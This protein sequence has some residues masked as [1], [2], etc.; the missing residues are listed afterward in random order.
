MLARGQPG[1]PRVRTHGH[2]GRG[3]VPR[4]RVRAVPDA[5]RRLRARSAG[6]DLGGRARAG[7]R[8]GAGG[9]VVVAVGPR[10]RR[11]RRGGD[12]GRMRL[13][14]RGQLRHGRDEHRRV[15]RSR[16]SSRTDRGAR[17]RGLPDPAPG[18]R[19]AH[20]GR[21]RWLDRA[22]RRGR[23]AGRGS[24]QRG[25]RAGARVLRPRRRRPDGHRRR[26]RARPHPRRFA[27]PGSRSARRCRGPPRARAGGRH[28]GRASCAS[29]TPRWNARCGS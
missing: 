11:A 28:R 24:A 26:S 21:G 14:R 1:V 8:R 5:A 27:L 10:G 20:G 19:R 29:S 16:S 9:G 7:D 3:G 2:D 13:R 22:A 25:S 6:D 15:P 23:R 17:R 4:A 12:R 18:A